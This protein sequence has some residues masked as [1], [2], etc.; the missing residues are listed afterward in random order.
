MGDKKK[1]KKQMVKLAQLATELEARASAIKQESKLLD[2]LRKDLD[3]RER[4]IAAA[5]TTASQAGKSQEAAKPAES[6]PQKPSL[7][8][9]ETQQQPSSDTLSEKTLC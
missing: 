6:E 8:G 3:A 7:S 9:T 2:A 1:N 4:A 5:E